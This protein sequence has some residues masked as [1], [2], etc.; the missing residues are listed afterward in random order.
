MQMTLGVLNDSQ[1]I[2]TKLLNLDLPFSLAYKI[3]KL[4][5]E[6]QP[7]LTFYTTELNKL[8]ATYAEREDTGYKRT[9]LGDI[10]LKP[11]TAGEFKTKF[12]EL[13]M[14]PIEIQTQVLT[15]AELT[16]LEEAGLKVTARE[17]ECYK[18]FLE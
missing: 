8:L 3:N 1:T 12:E 10:Q 13:S 11:D 16:K 5:N 6:L 17:I 9:P 15:W 4:I 18:Y 7:S 2:L 14:I